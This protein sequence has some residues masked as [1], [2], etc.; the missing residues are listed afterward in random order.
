ML[1][2]SLSLIYYKY[3]FV[4]KPECIC[5][6]IRL[7]CW[8]LPGLGSSERWHHNPVSGNYSASLNDQRALTSSQGLAFKQSIRATT[9]T[10]T[11]N[12]FMGIWCPRELRHNIFRCSNPKSAG[13]VQ[14][15]VRHRR[16][17]GVNKT[18]KLNIHSHKVHSAEW[19]HEKL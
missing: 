18:P 2:V 6:S 14:I 4:E 19:Y 5:K 11:D 16:T 17:S 3:L 13:V 12:D 1:S 8:S 10:S 7:R 15:Q 9:R